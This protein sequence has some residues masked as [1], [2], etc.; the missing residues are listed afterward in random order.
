MNKIGL[1]D[2][3]GHNFPN[4]ALMKISKYHKNI[5]DKVSFASIGNY[6][7]VYMSKV[8]TFT[9]DYKLGFVEYD[10]LYKGGTGYDLIKKL[11]EE[12]DILPPD[13]ALYP[14]Y[15]AAYG[16]LTRGCP[17]KCDYCIVPKKEG[18]INKYADIEDFLEGRRSAILM[19]NNVLAHNHGLEQIEKIIKLNIQIDFNQGLDA[20]IIANNITIAKLLSK[21]NWIKHIRISCDT[22]R[23]IPIVERALKNL[24][25]FGIEG[26]QV[27]IYIL[28][29][30]I[31][32]ALER[33][34]FFKNKGYYMTFAQP[35]HDFVTNKEPSHELKRLARWC[36][37]KQ[38]FYKTSFENYYSTKFEKYKILNDTFYKKRIKHN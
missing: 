19:D 3:D 16:F 34:N 23:H 12:I 1:I 8:F 6:D 26:N 25:K 14:M 11:P 9:N 30:E 28:V 10:E 27:F 24:K 2:V 29:K 22:K 35:F 7:K 20:R 32:D 5:G 33:I 31:Q 21:I 15:K 37:R 38:I 13:Y 36:N 18:N 4:L 17:N